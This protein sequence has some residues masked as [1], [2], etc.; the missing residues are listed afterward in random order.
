MLHLLQ[1]VDLFALDL[2]YL[3]DGLFD[4]IVDIL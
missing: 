1:S 3:I 4:F 2:S